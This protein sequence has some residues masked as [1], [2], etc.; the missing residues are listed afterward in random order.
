MYSF[1]SEYG[2]EYGTQ[3][4]IPKHN[5]SPHSLE[6][7]HKLTNDE[8]IRIKPVDEGEAIVIW[9]TK[10]YLIEAYR[11]RNNENHYPRLLLRITRVV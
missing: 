8:N 2:T 7:T 3:R 4:H 5:M 11:K 1:T 6:T 10:D 9:Q